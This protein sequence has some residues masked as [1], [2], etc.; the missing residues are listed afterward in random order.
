MQPIAMLQFM[1][2]IAGSGRS[3]TVDATAGG[4]QLAAAAYPDGTKVVK[5]Q[6]QAQDCRMTTDG[7][8]PVAT[9]TGDI[10]RADTWIYLSLQQAIAAK[11]IRE[12]A[13]SAVVRSEALTY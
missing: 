11:F 13:S 3:L 7:T 6:V 10:L 2:T 12:G 1:K 9:T 5:I 8:A 4:V